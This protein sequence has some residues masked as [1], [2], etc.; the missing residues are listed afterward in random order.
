MKWLSSALA[1]ALLGLASAALAS[2]LAITKHSAL[3]LSTVGEARLALAAE[4]D[5]IRALS[6]FDRASRMKVEAPPT[7]EEFLKLLI[8]IC[9]FEAM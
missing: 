5:F 8:G 3:R 7:R 2:D 6:E 9:F 1:V 4:D